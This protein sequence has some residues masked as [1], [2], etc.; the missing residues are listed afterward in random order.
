MC[1]ARSI[2]SLAWLALRHGSETEK[3][4]ALRLVLQG[5]HDGDSSVRETAL[6]W[7]STLGNQDVTATVSAL[8]SALNDPSA[9]FRYAAVFE[10]G[11]LG[12]NYSEAQ[13]YVVPVLSSVFRADVRLTI[14]SCACAILFGRPITPGRAAGRW[15]RLG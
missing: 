1:R 15:C 6:C 13:R 11:T 14:S 3:Q 8:E 9:E 7:L 12:S 2:Y 4:Q 5:L 10:L